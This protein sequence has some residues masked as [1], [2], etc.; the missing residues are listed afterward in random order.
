MTVSLQI[1]YLFI[2]SIPVALFT[3]NIRFVANEP[4]VYRYA[5]DEYGAV[6]T[7][8]IGRDEL[9]KAGAANARRVRGRRDPMPPFELL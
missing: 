9:L 5:I 1:I 3:T 4:R 2:L 8:G 6:G 7:T